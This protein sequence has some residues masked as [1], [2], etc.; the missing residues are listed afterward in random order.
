MLCPSMNVQG[1]DREFQL[2]QT[3]ILKESTLVVR[4]LLKE[5]VFSRL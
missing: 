1:C 2:Q 3:L 5:K 4:S